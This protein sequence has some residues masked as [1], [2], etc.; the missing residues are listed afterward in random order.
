MAVIL[1]IC[2]IVCK[3]GNIRSSNTGVYEVTNVW[4]MV[5]VAIQLDIIATHLVS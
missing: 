5:Q 3:F 2:Y 1:L 4:W